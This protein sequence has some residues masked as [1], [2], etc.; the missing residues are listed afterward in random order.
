[1][2]EF[3]VPKLSS[4]EKAD[5]QFKLNLLKELCANVETLGVSH[6]EL[7]TNVFRQLTTIIPINRET[8]TGYKFPF[9]RTVINKD[10][11]QK[12]S[13]L[14]S[15]T[16]LRYPPNEVVKNLSYNR[17]NLKQQAIFYG[18]SHSFPAIVETKPKEGQLITTSQW[19]IKQGCEI[20]QFVICQDS[21]I[22][23]QNDPFL[24]ERYN[25]HLRMLQKLDPDTLSI[26]DGIYDFIVQAFTKV[27]NPMNKQ[28]YLISALFAD[29][30][31]NH[32]SPK[33]DAIIYPS[34]AFNGYTLNI[35]VTPNCLNACFKMTGVKE[36][37][38]TRT[39]DGSDAKWFGLITGTAEVDSDIPLRLNWKNGLIPSDEMSALSK[40]Y[41][42]SLE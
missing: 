27:V 28:G 1:M 22:A 39:P 40:R 36:M 29:Q 3:V 32:G 37:L 16:N 2:S 18:A 31:L 13:R 26:I 14:H 19:E 15:L 5:A 20:H 38:V 24:L 35:A 12:N 34:V 33:V 6:V 7:V 23:A 21:D 10:V 9:V 30:M 11:I 4:S 8:V 17:A 41:D 42:F 25:E